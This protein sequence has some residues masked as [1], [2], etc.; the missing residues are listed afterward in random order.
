MRAVVLV[1]LIGCGKSGEPSKGEDGVLAIVDELRAEHFFD[2]PFPSD[3]LLTAAGRPDLT[4]YPLPEPDLA[5]G[6]LG[7]WVER[8]EQATRGFGNNTP[9]YFRF[10]RPLSLPSATEGRPDDPVLWVALDGSELLPL[11]LR[12]VAD[13]QGDPMYAPN[14]LAMAPALGHPMRSGGTY[15]AVVMRS[16][17]VVAPEGYALPDGVTDA[18]S[19]AGVTGQAAVATVFTVQ[20][21]VG[22]LRALK[23][24]VESRLGDWPE[25][26]LRRVVELDYRQGTTPSGKEATVATARFEDGTSR[27][28]YME[29]DD[30]LEDATF[31][32]LDWP[33]AVWETDIPVHNYQGLD[34]RP[35]MSAGLLHIADAGVRTGWI[36]IEDGQV[37]SEPEL[38]WMRVTIQLPKDGDGAVVDADGVVI[39][40]HG[41][42]GHAYNI[43]QRR[44]PVDRNRELAQRFADAR[45]AVIGR[46]ASLY[47]ARYPL[48]DEGY[49]GSLGFYNIVNA[50]AFRDNHRQTAL[51]GHVLK[52][53]I[54][55]VLPGALP[56]GSVDTSRIRRMGHSLGSVT[57]NNAMAM[58]PA[59]YEAG[60]L[61][62]TGGVFLHYFFDTGLLAD[63]DPTVIASLFPL[64]GA[65]P[66]EVITTTSVLGAVLGL[67]EPAWDHLDRL[68]PG[69]ALWQWMIDPS[70]PMALARDIE[71]PVTA[72]IAPGD[73]QTPDFTAEALVGAMPDA[74][75]VPC[76]ATWDY[77]PHYC[78][79]REEE[80]WDALGTWLSE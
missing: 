64:V 80:G 79:W 35:Y 58:D 62:G 49:G 53:W 60:F 13:P 39:F 69:A 8:V 26:E 16:A 9:A 65:Q 21:A 42:A 33:T 57:A 51:D 17:G 67:P 7:S 11:Q 75:A 12:F 27:V 2:V 30:S 41:T 66:P 76:H 72:L 68:H 48:I 77:D 40:D 24:D 32:L 78:I 52:R 70:D 15:A 19:A 38:E 5:R 25:P 59:G 37:R 61:S 45:F 10:E 20:D 73:H 22:E 74:V 56:E 28:A 31:D 18:L 44:S 3:T 63:I 36:D 43:V 34:Q 54:E 1:A 47:G 4:G 6:I 46:D 55:E 23:A 71:V 29:A 50:P 14:T